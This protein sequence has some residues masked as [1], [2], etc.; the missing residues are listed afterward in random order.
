MN[1]AANLMGF[2]AVIL[3]QSPRLILAAIPSDLLDDERCAG[4]GRFSGRRDSDHI[5]RR[6]NGLPSHA[7]RLVQ[8]DKKKPPAMRGQVLFPIG[9]SYSWSTQL[10][11]DVISVSESVQR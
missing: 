2:M 7:S 3:V 4:G 8:T 9:S 1:V 6:L 5:M 10:L 11:I